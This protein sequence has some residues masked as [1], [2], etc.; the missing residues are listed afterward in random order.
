MAVVPPHKYP[1]RNNIRESLLDGC[2]MAALYSA[3]ASIRGAMHGMLPSW[4]M[5]V[6]R[7][8]HQLWANDNFHRRR[9]ETRGFCGGSRVPVTI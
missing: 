4:A 6:L 7:L 5:Q 3:H 9:G 2:Q 8:I 1:L